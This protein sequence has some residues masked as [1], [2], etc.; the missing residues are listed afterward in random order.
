M[1]VIGL[2]IGTTTI[3]AVVYQEELGVLDARTVKNDAFLPGESWEKIQDPQVIYEKAMASLRE[4]LDRHPDVQAIGITGQMHGILYLDGTGNPVSPLYIW[5]DGRGDLPYDEHTT[6]AQHLADL[7]G[8]EA[9]TG[10]GMVTHYYNLHHGLVPQNANLFCT[11]QDFLAMKLAGLSQPRMEATDA[12]SLGL[13]DAPN[14][15]FD[16]NALAAADI[17]PNLIPRMTTTPYLG[18]GPLGLPVF[19]A[20]GD[21]QASFLGATGGRTD[22]LLVNIG[23]GGQISVYAPR[24]VKAPTLETRPFPNGGW[25]LVG[26]SLCGG[27]AYALLENFFRQTVQMVTGSDASLYDAMARMLDTQPEPENPPQILPLF[28]G[29]RKNPTLRGSITGLGTENFTPL[30]FAYGV[31]QGMA[32]ELY[33]LFR[34]YLDLGGNPPAAIIGSGNGLRK[35]PHLCRIMEK[36]FGC[37]LVLSDNPEEA[38]CGAAIYAAKHCK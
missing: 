5:Q 25:L 33:D 35:N 14:R 7:T 30:D 38:A 10:Y 24:Y 22:V 23:T 2:D 31:M 6:W 16:V 3:S 18:T 29:T 12:A 4:M 34:G 11:I 15:C 26:A 27:R 20:I 19:V 28:Q 37:P 1:K 17:D 21:N 9:A 32:Q 13:Y 36:T 8:Y